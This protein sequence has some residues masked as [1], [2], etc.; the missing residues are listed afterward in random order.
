MKTTKSELGNEQTSGMLRSVLHE[1]SKGLFTGMPAI[2]DTY[3]AQARTANVIPALRKVMKDG[4]TRE[5]TML[6]N[7]PVM[8]PSAGGWSLAFNDLRRGDTVM[9]IFSMRGIAGFKETHKVE[10][11]SGGILDMGSAV[12]I[13]GF[14]PTEGVS[15]PGISLTKD[16][17][18]VRLDLAD[19]EVVVDVDGGGMTLKKD[20]SVEFANG[21]KINPLG[22]FIDGTGLN[23]SLHVHATV[24]SLGTPSGPVS[25]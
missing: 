17:G 22:Q 10:D 23:Y 5:R 15:S 19:D 16:D 4:G 6:P 13:V 18:S 9:L 25:P 7:V 12:A 8:F 11:A 24:A 3:D 20:K 1:W 2:V 14:G 21:A